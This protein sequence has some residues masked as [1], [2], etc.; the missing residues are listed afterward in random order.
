M[1]WEN[2]I[3]PEGRYVDLK[4]NETSFENQ[5]TNL[6]DTGTVDQVESTAFI[7]AITASREHVNMFKEMIR[8]VTDKEVLKNCAKA[9]RKVQ[10]FEESQ[11]K[12][13]LTFS[14]EKIKVQFYEILDNF[15]FDE[16]NLSDSDDFDTPCDSPVFSPSTSE[17]GFYENSSET[18]DYVGN[19]ENTLILD[20]DT[21][22]KMPISLPQFKAD[23][24]PNCRS[25]I[26]S[27][28]AIFELEAATYN[29][30]TKKLAALK[31]CTATEPV[32]H[33]LVTSFVSSATEAEKTFA[34][35]SKKL[36]DAFDGT[37]VTNKQLLLK[38]FTTLK[39]GELS[40]KDYFTKAIRIMEAK[41]V[42][43]EVL[44]MQFIQNLKSEQVKQILLAKTGDELKKIEKVF[45]I[46]QGMAGKEETEQKKEDQMGV[47]SM[48]RFNNPGRGNRGAGYRGGRSR[49]RSFN[50]QGR[51]NNNQRCDFCD[52]PNHLW[53]QCPQVKQMVQNRGNN[54]GATY[55]RGQRTRGRTY[56]VRGE[57]QPR[58]DRYQEQGKIE[59]L[60]LNKSKVV[61]FN[62]EYLTLFDSGSDESLC[63]ISEFSRNMGRKFLMPGN[64]SF[65]G[66]GQKEV[67]PVGKAKINYIIP[68]TGQKLT[69]F[70]YL[71][72]DGAIDVPF[73]LGKKDLA[74]ING[75][76]FE[77]GINFRGNASFFSDIARSKS[78]VTIPAES[79]KTLLVR[80]SKNLIKNRGYTISEKLENSPDGRVVARSLSV[81]D[82]DGNLKVLVYNLTKKE[83]T[84]QENEKLGKVLAA[85]AISDGVEVKHT[86]K[87]IHKKHLPEIE[88]EDELYKA[89]FSKLAEEYADIFEGIG[90]IADYEVKLKVQPGFTESYSK[91]RP[92]DPFETKH[93]EIEKEELE[94]HDM[95]E[96]APEQTPFMSNVC[97]VF[98]KVGPNSA[99]LKFRLTV[100]YKNINEGLIK[101]CFPLPGRFFIL[102]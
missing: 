43:E 4:N 15:D 82:M 88:T 59:N 87:D 34:N 98:E 101:E 3:K 76:N 51:Q 28:E 24:H 47:Y 19:L 74:K 41:V 5:F 93:I 54:R 14:L 10:K 48:R 49:G 95:I 40:N 53:R 73:L 67:T 68:E 62:K 92:F 7:E 65:V 84:I 8:Q 13:T 78:T 20:P 83:I 27:I 69:S 56:A 22:C 17:I 77:N 6:F 99:D 16:V 96:D 18:D 86:I 55:G 58:Q 31:F 66:L 89:K 70:F 90:V 33:R 42:T 71:V 79:M 9:C 29:T 91:R 12:F 39:Q 80:T 72:P 11:S 30:E 85:K 21:N 81:P 25:L 61:F 35:I 63:R 37:D 60:S 94:K 100:N 23:K 46:I 50:F 32:M 102:C 52:D 57:E 38:E 45:E 26:H 97:P 1:N 44:C 75:L 36:A 64:V 2:K